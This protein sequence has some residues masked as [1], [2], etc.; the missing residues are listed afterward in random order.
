MKIEITQPDDWHLH[1]RDGEPMQDIVTYTA[2]QFSR[3]IIMPNLKPPITTVAAALLY[4][5]RILTAVGSNY[6]FNP[7]MA[8]YLTDNTPTQEI[9]NINDSEHV[10]AVKYYP[11]GATTNSD[12]GVTHLKKTYKV[13]AAMEKHG[14]PLLIHGE[15][16][17][18]EIDVFDR[19]KIFIDKQLIGLN[20]TFPALKIVLEHITTQDAVDFLLSTDKHVAATITPHHLLLN[21]NAMFVGGIQPHHYCLPVLKREKHRKA[22][23]YAATSGNP[24]FFLGTDSA[25]H[26]KTN[27]EAHCGCAG[28]FSAPIALEL[29][30]TAFESANALNKLEGFCSF[31][32]ADFYGLPRNPNKITLLKQQWQVP[33]RL[34]FG[35][36][37]LVPFF[38]GQQLKWKLEPKFHS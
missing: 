38:S 25:P 7:L 6:A 23:I 28:I 34:K 27:K 17:N 11:A 30:A 2:Q 15:V 8:L 4:R 29:Y 37:E 26:S 19:E 10:V 5:Q 21:R 31:Y 24:K 3:A 18:P 35:A 33:T 20:R 12:A 22:L 14:I 1:I 16:T 9:L 36:E 13:L 32:G